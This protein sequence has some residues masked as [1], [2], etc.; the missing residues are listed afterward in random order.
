MALYNF[1]T[2]LVYSFVLLRFL[3][4]DV[5][6]SFVLGNPTVVRL[7]SYCSR[8][9]VKYRKGFLSVF[10]EILEHLLHVFEH[11][12]SVVSVGCSLC[13]FVSPRVTRSCLG[14]SW[15]RCSPLGWCCFLLFWVATGCGHSSNISPFDLS[16]VRSFWICGFLYIS[17]ILR[18]QYTCCVWATKFSSG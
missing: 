5:A 14:C 2:S 1:N 17:G 3:S 13:L 6:L 11:S 18:V 4:S 10:K 12:D 16:I 7:E 8:F 15:Y 9:P